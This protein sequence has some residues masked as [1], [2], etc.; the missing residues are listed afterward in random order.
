MSYNHFIFT[1][2][3]PAI[4]TYAGR[5]MRVVSHID[6]DG[7]VMKSK[8]S[9]MDGALLMESTRELIER[10]SKLEVVMLIHNEG[11]ITKNY[12]LY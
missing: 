5:E 10:D 6:I 3:T 9:T 1:D 7:N 4:Q 8:S 11:K 2:A 12:Q